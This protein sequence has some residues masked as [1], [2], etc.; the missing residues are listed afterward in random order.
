MFAEEIRKHLTEDIIPFWEKL[1]DK[2]YDGYY[3]VVDHE[4][5]VHPDADKGGILNSRILWFFSNCAAVLGSET[6]LK[7][8]EYAYR[9][10][11][12]HFLDPEYGGIYWSVTREGKPSDTQKHSYNQAFA[13]YG[14]SSYYGASGND[15]AREIAMGLY[16][17]VETYM[18]DD[19]GYL[20][21]FT[22]DL[23]PAS[24]EK[25]AEGT[26]AYRTMNSLL[27]LLEAYTEL[28]RVT[29]DPDV[30]KSICFMLDIV[31]EHIY[32]PEL[33]RLECFFDRDYRTLQDLHSYGHDIEA[34]WLVE[35]T[36]E[37]LDD[38]AYT[39]KVKPLLISIMKNT[40]AKG[41]SGD[42]LYNDCTDGRQD[43][44]AVWWVQAETTVALLNAYKNFPEEK[45]YYD[46]ALRVW[47]FI[48]NNQIDRRPGC[49]EWKSEVLPDGT[50]RGL[51]LVNPWK[52]PYHNGRMCLEALKRLAD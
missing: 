13:I 18:K 47:E 2:E 48:K 6:Y 39:N 31:A 16:R 19:K 20:E 11:R 38:P 12:D 8:A 33:Q 28:Y 21:A 14:L 49:G 27:H 46:K 7:D 23:K 50:D 45:G 35:R 10:L 51:D 17:L 5:T 4:L 32:N 26:A 22:R 25:L 42:Y 36:L 15:E 40:L 41:F 30:R 52:C 44:T 34:S 1:Q 24:N 29:K 3:G 9:M 37:I 43:R